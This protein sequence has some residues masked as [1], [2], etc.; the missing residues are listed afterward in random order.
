MAPERYNA[1]QTLGINSSEI[2]SSAQTVVSQWIIIVSWLCL[3]WAICINCVVV[4]AILA[5]KKRQWPVFARLILCTSACDLFVAVSCVPVLVNIS[6]LSITHFAG[7]LIIYFFFFMGQLASLFHILGICVH[8]TLAIKTI[9]SKRNSSDR[10]FAIVLASCAWVVAAVVG[11]IP[12][13]PLLNSSNELRTCSTGQLFGNQYQGTN[14]LRISYIIPPFLTNVFYIFACIRFKM[15]LTQVA[16]ASGSESQNVA[17]VNRTQPE[18]DMHT[19][20]QNRIQATF[21][22]MQRTV[23]VTIGCVMLFNNF[24]T[25]PIIAVFIREFY[26]GFESASLRFIGSFLLS[27]H[28]VINPVVYIC[29][30]TWLR[31]EIKSLFQDVWMELRFVCMCWPCCESDLQDI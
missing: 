25:L 27:M 23:L 1:S 14:V 20:Q 7:C 6:I 5:N 17:Q 2:I 9:L 15:V 29:Q 24:L 10:N 3:I 19:A 16:P 26:F 28:S 13:I 18:S 22:R 11:M 12:F 21:N 8:R 30:M 4:S 31:R